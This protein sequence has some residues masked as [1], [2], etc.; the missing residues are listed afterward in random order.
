MKHADLSNEV[1]KV[2][3]SCGSTEIPYTVDYIIGTSVVMTRRKPALEEKRGHLTCKL[4]N[5]V[6]YHLAKV[7]ATKSKATF[8]EV[9]SN[10]INEKKEAIKRERKKKL[11]PEVM[12]D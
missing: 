12:Q 9:I 3:K 11:L 6:L 4:K 8:K 10:V 5:I 7:K 2:K 1:D